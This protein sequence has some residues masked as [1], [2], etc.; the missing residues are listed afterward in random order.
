CL[1][2]FRSDARIRSAASKDPT[3]SRTGDTTTPFYRGRRAFECQR[4]NEEYPATGRFDLNQIT[5]SASRSG[6]FAN[7]DAACPASLSIVN[8]LSLFVERLTIFFIDAAAFVSSSLAAPKIGTL[9]E[10]LIYASPS[11]SV[12]PDSKTSVLISG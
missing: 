10:L 7:I 9:V 8:W 12:P 3:A 11:A 1:A 5:I 6:C 4:R 2:L